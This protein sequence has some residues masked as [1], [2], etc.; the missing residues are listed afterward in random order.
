MRGRTQTGAASATSIVAVVLALVVAAGIGILATVLLTGDD[1]GD[2]EAK[3]SESA[4]A[5]EDMSEEELSEAIVEA[6][7]VASESLTELTETTIE[8]L[9]DDVVTDEEYDYIYG[10][11]DDVYEY[12][13]YAE[14]MIEGYYEFYAEYS[15]EV[16]VYLEGIEDDLEAIAEANQSIA[17]SLDEAE[18]DLAAFEETVGEVAAELEAG[19]EEFAADLEAWSQAAAE[20]RQANLAELEALKPAE[21]PSDRREAFGML[22][23]YADG[24]QSALADK[25]ISRGERSDLLQQGVDLQSALGGFDGDFGDMGSRVERFNRQLAVGEVPSVRQDLP[26]FQHQVPSFEKPS[27]TGGGPSGGGRSGGGPSG[28]GGRSDGGGR[29]GGGGRP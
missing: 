19:A 5:V 23:G 3:I 4:E 7:E 24:L 22:Q 6:V 8:Y 16:T 12:T 21:P 20:Q 2:G 10:Y 14:V 18:E 29:S 11:V 25:K 13:A 9:E 28:G 1:S 15:A 27:R 17:D 26:D